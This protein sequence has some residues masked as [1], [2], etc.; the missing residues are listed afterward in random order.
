MNGLIADPVLFVVIQMEI[1]VNSSDGIEIN[2]RATGNQTHNV[3]D[4]L[5]CRKVVERVSTERFGRA[6][7]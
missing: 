5:D 2:L 4:S 3:A 6:I 1:E 7:D